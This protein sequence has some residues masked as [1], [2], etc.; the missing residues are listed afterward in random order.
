MCQSDRTWHWPS[1]TKTWCRHPR[2]LLEKPEPKSSVLTRPRSNGVVWGR[3]DAPFSVVGFQR[4]AIADRLM[5]ES[6]SKNSLHF[7]STPSLDSPLS[8]VMRSLVGDIIDLYEPNRRTAAQTL[9]ELPTWFHKG[10]FAGKMDP[11][12]G[13]GDGALDWSSV[14]PALSSPSGQWI[15]EDLLVEVSCSCG[16]A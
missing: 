6:S 9:M 12:K 15:F 2:M 14:P 3:K 11:N 1:S 5:C 7:Q 4:L 13:F 8:V 16:M 10:T